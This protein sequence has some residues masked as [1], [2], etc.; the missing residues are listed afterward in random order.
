[1]WQ[2]ASELH[3]RL[4]R[5]RQKEFG[6]YDEPSG[7]RHSDPLGLTQLI[8]AH[9]ILSAQKSLLVRVNAND[10]VAMSGHVTSPHASPEGI[11]S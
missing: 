11:D 8:L 5:L 1:M 7:H 10:Y 9:R 6:A 3:H 2:H 4:H